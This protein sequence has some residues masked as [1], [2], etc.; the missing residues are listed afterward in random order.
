VDVCGLMLASPALAP[1][2]VVYF[3]VYILSLLGFVGASLISPLL[4]LG[5]FVIGLLT[6]Y[7][8]VVVFWTLAECIWL[9]VHYLFW[10]R[11]SGKDKS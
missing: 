8:F 5:V 11:I 7:F 9:P 1:L 4:G 6:I 2:I 3:L 10:K